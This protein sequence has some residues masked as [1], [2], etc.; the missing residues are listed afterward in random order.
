[1]SAA[2]IKESL[3]RRPFEPFRI[4]LSSGDSLEVRHPEHALM[5]RAGVYVAAP[6]EKGELPEAATWCSLL[7]VT[8]IEPIAKAK[9]GGKSR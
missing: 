3:S 4:R 9:G 2:A 1:M 8:A 5:V 7:R 6:D